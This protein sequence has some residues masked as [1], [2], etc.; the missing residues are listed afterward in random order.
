M[1]DD[2]GNDEQQL[3]RASEAPKAGVPETLGPDA[4]ASVG[5]SCFGRTGVCG[6]G[7]PLCMCNMLRLEEGRVGVL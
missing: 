7:P 2:L 5:E 4:K 6:G 1:A 3:S